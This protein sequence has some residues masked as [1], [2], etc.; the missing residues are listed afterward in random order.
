MSL[1]H[2]IPAG[3]ASVLLVG[4]TALSAVASPA[5]APASFA[6]AAADDDALESQISDGFKHNSLLAPRSIDVEV[7]QGVVTLTG[8]VRDAKEKSQAAKVAKVKGVARVSNQLEIDPKIDESKIDNAADKTKAGLNK[9]V[10]ATVGAAEKAKDG[11]KKG[12]GKS[13]EGVSKAADKTSEA[14]NKAGDKAND[15]AIT[16]KVK[17]DLAAENSL[18]DSAIDV[19]TV[20]HVVTLRGSVASDQAKARAGTLAGSAQGVTRVDN[21]LVVRK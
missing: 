12:V 5:V 16:T 11:V 18:K 21:E 17:T 9:A 10:D 6:A 14:V 7:K 13:E 3:I 1:K 19:Q 20:D 8:K 15:A 2:I 4:G